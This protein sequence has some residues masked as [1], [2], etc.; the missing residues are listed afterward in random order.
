MGLLQEG[1]DVGLGS[2]QVLVLRQVVEGT[3]R[4]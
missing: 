2:D 1:E 4:R 3:A